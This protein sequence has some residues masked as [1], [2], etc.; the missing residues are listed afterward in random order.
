[1]AVTSYVC[2]CMFKRVCAGN[3]HERAIYERATYEST[4]HGRAL[5]E[6][7][8]HVR[9]THGLATYDARPMS[10]QQIIAQPMSA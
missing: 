8:L 4:S 2:I 10:T 1:M 6:R 3:T 9:A 5:H 7:A